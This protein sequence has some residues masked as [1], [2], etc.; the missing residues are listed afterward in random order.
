MTRH[1]FR[2]IDKLFRQKTKD[3]TAREEPILLKK[4]RKGDAAWGT[5]KV[6]LGWAIDTVKQVPTLLEEHKINLLAL[7]I[8]IPPSA[9]RCSWRRW[10]KILGTLCSTVP[11]IEGAAGMFT[12]LQHAL[13]SAKGR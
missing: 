8:T 10:H 5:Q 1:L 2:T 4:L 6:V 3:D 13:I 9:S 12:R 11:A 7:R